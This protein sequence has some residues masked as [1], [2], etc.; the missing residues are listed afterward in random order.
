[1]AESSNLFPRI[2]PRDEA[3]AKPAETAV[4]AKPAPAKGP[5]PEPVAPIEFADFQKLDLRI[6]KVLA[7][8]Q[9]PN[10]DKLLKVMVDLGEESPRQ[11]LAGMAAYFAPRDMVGR[12]VTVVANLAPRKMRGL[13]SQ[14]MILA[15]HTD[16]GLE[17]L[18]PGGP[19]A[20]GAKVS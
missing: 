15:V 17:L 11:I 20:P 16:S 7:C 6:G 10:A 5:A 8:E 12:M 19:A 3:P 4:E 9:H 13:E 18:T 2:E 1:M 14:G